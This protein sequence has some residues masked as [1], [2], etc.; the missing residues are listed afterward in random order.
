MAMTP[1]EIEQA[2]LGMDEVRIVIR[3]P[4]NARLGDYSYKRKAADNASVTEWL[5][6]RIRP[7]AS[8]HEVVVIDGN[9]ASP[10][11]RTKLATLRASYEH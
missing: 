2:V 4:A 1:A 8:G 6:Q 5:D 3:A 9:G 7:I 11:G 10:H